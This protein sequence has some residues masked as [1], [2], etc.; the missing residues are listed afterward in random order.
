[1]RPFTELRR[2][3]LA[4]HLRKHVAGEVRFDVVSR[5]LYSTDASI[6]QIE[7]LGVVI[8]RSVED[9]VATVQI[10]AETETPITPRG[11]ALPFRGSPS[12]AASSLIAA[13]TLTRL[14]TSIQE[15]AGHGSQPGVVLDQLNQAAG[16]HH[17]Q[18]GPEVSTSSRANLGGM[19][20]NN[21]AGSRSIVYGKTIDHVKHLE[22][23][24]ADGRRAGFGPLTVREWESCADKQTPDAKLHHLIRT[25]ILNY[26]EEILAHFPT[27]LR[28]VSGYNLDTLCRGLTGQSSSPVG[29]HQL[30]VGSEGTLALTVEAELNLIPRPR[31]RGLL[32]PRFSSFAAAMDAVAACLEL[33]PSAVEVMDGL[34]LRLTASNLAL[35]DTMSLIPGT[36]E[37]V[38]MVEF[39][40][41]DLRW[42]SDRIEQ[43]ERR[44]RGGAGVEGVTRALDAAVRDPLW[45]LRKAAMPLLY[46]MPGDRKPVTFVEDCAVA[47]AQLPE[48]AARFREILQKHG[49]DGAFYG[50]ASVGCLHIRP[51][52]N[53]KEAAE[54]ARMRQITSEVTDLVLSYGGSLSGEHGDGLAR[55]EWNPKMFGPQVYQAFCQVKQ[56]FDPRGLLNPGRVVNGP[57]MTE[58]LRYAPGYQTADLPTIYNYS[59]QGGF[60]RATE[61]C[62][63]N[64][65]CRK[66]E[67]GTMCPSYRATRDEQDSP[68]GRANVLRLALAGQ[69]PLRDL[70]SPKPETCLTSA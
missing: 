21:S 11:G 26:R 57:P 43:L 7:P 40:G 20:G 8:P 45:N 41:S 46:S 49:T 39:S 47:P 5:R 63:G 53:L 64:G 52:L 19:I 50:H 32:V 15:C 31:V 42:V 38:L 13:N 9:L 69:Q 65:A 12:A 6:Y 2:K 25:L 61:M 37:A 66:R 18:F 4:S 67:G 68:R 17:L 35:R 59:Q 22:V 23:I 10:A 56:I 36:P 51:V 54:V 28:R 62:N 58:N 27:I 48:F 16:V 55:S 14:S 30:I 24:L 34:L 29:L 33:E 60:A 3:S 1:M 44:L 70:R